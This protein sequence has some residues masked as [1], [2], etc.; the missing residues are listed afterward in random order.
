MKKNK[1]D[2]IKIIIINITMFKVCNTIN[3]VN[4]KV[5]I[6]HSMKIYCKILVQYKNKSD[7]NTNI[8]IIKNSW[9]IGDEYIGKTSWA[10]K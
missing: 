5:N 6:N 10:V 2:Y 4:R 7:K 9:I 3:T 1:I 8:K